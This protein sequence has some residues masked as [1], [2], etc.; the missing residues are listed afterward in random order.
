MVVP[1]EGETRKWVSYWSTLLYTVSF[2]GMGSE[3]APTV[4]TYGFISKSK[5]KWN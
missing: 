2:H 5:M 4:Y 3:P 1:S